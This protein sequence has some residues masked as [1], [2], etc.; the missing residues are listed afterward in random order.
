VTICQGENDE[1]IEVR[2]LD[3]VGY[4]SD[5][6]FVILNPLR[7][8]GRSLSTE[9]DPL[10]VP[11]C[12]R[13]KIANNQVVNFSGKVATLN[14]IDGVWHYQFRQSRRPPRKLPPYTFFEIG[15]A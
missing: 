6:A 5:G 10:L 11:I 12:I 7:S 4:V 1:P 15:D 2:T 9:G 13:A 14:D 3:V 8:A